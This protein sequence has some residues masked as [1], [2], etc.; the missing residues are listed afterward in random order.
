MN[1]TRKLSMPV[2]AAC[3]ILAAGCY[4]VRLEPIPPVSTGEP[5]DLTAKIDTPP[6]TAASKR[7]IRSGMAGVANSWTV[8]IGDAVVKYAAAYLSEAFPPGDDVTVRVDLIDYKVEGFAATTDL[9]FVV[10]DADRVLF[11]RNYRCV[12]DGYG[13]RVVLGGA[14]AMKSAMRRTT[15]DSLRSCFEQ[16]LVDARAEE[17]RWRRAVARTGQGAPLAEA[18]AGAGGPEAGTTPEVAGE[19]TR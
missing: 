8:D 15:D 3:V 16:F 18:D 14:F 6:A 17:P 19:T 5:M 2:L 7:T 1:A 11:D 4:T 10:T 13:G 12:G 9:R